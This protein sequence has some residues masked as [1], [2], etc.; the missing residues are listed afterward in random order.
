MS[1]KKTKNGHSKYLEHHF[2]TLERQFHSGKLG[3]WIFLVTEVLFFSGL[4]CWYAIT[5]SNHPEIFIYAHK[6]LDKSLGGLNTVILLTSS[7]TMAM[8]VRAAQMSQKKLLVTMLTLTVICAIGFMGVK[9]IEY[10][11]KWKHGLLPG[12]YYDPV[13]HESAHES[14]STTVNQAA[15][16]TPQS[17]GSAAP[18]TIEKHNFMTG[19]NVEGESPAGEGVNKVP[20]PSSE[21]GAH[22]KTLDKLHQ[23]QNDAT[24][25]DNDN[26]SASALPQIDQSNIKPAAE[27]PGGLAEGATSALGKHE[28]TDVPSNVQAFFSIY[29]IMTG[30]HALHL[31]I[32]IAGLLVL[33]YYANRGLYKR[34]FFTP[35]ELFGLYWHFVDL[36]WIYLFPMLY[37]IH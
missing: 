32:G 8:A 35:V 25:G 20:L 37:L 10:N 15:S 36:V 34:E 9:G 33:I 28:T 26:T 23:L 16:D 31:V 7:F 17:S 6:Y 13:S 14:D 19:R 22:G 3:M 21:T 11:S 2:D 27:G 30:I 18:E 12:K 5:R 24:A 4:F 1:Q 29:F